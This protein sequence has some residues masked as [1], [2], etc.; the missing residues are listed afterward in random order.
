MVRVQ[1]SRDAQMAASLTSGESA[2]RGV[3]VLIA[4]NFHSRRDLGV[5]NYIADSEALVS[6]ALVEL[7]DDSRD[8]RDYVA[9]LGPGLSYDYLWFTPAVETQDY[10][11]QLR[12]DAL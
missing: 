11:A 7:S 4:G 1:R 8:P 10:C 6:V 2:N 12:A 5:P 9:D 3:N